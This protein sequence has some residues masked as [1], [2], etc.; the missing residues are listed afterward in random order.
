MR[1]TRLSQ[2]VDANG[3]LTDDAIERTLDVLRHYRSI[4]DH[5]D[6]D[7]GL[8]VATSAVRDASNG[9]NFLAA[10]AGITGVQSRCLTGKEEATFTYRGA[11][12]SLAAS[13]QSTLVVDIGGG[14]TEM[15]VM[16]EGALVSHSMQ[17]GCVRVTERALGADVVTPPRAAAARDLIQRE[18]ERAWREQPSFDA[19]RGDLRLVGV[20]GTV[21][22]LA[23][24]V[25][26]DDEYERDRVHH[27]SL[28]RSDVQYWIAT[29]G[30][31]TP[32]E[33][34]ALPGMVA[35]REDVLVSGLMILDAVMERFAVTTLMTSED[36]I[37]D[38]VGAWC[39]TAQ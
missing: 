38:G 2:G 23:Q 4:M 13:T 8:L 11:T 16:V 35:G 26:G 22:T 25:A 29:L 9:G 20:A 18:V 3:A 34:L 24:L 14:S 1:I 12:A 5:Y 30:G 15:A 21:A 28:H 36:D 39:A 27:Q 32:S 19:V 6:V 37:L 31:L 33:R 17:L 10:A 7:K